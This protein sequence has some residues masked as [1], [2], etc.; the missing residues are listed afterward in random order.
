[1]RLEQSY[2][3]VLISYQKHVIN[4]YNENHTSNHYLRICW[5]LLA[6]QSGC[7]AGTDMS[8]RLGRDQNHPQW[9]KAPLPLQ[10]TSRWPIDEIDKQRNL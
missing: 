3:A 1:M 8:T 7:P 2:N 9:A 5:D 4:I 10:E 6:A